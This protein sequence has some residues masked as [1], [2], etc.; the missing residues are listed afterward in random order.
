MVIPEARI[1][2]SENNNN[3]EQATDDGCV[4]KFGNERTKKKIIIIGVLCAVVILS[5][6]AALVVVIIVNNHAF[7]NTK[8]EYA[9]PFSE[10]MQFDGGDGCPAPPSKICIKTQKKSLK[11][12]ED[13]TVYIYYGTQGYLYDP[14]SLDYATGTLSMSYDR[15]DPMCNLETISENNLLLATDYVFDF[16]REPLAVTIPAEAFVEKEALK[17]PVKF[18]ENE[19]GIVFVYEARYLCHGAPEEYSWWDSTIIYYKIDNDNINLYTSYS[20]LKHN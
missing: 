6:S 14:D 1:M 2:T 19:G 12:G 20:G 4:P 3:T 17:D 9:D 11:K 16:E 8:T 15:Y 7:S 5:L 10:G 18:T 13:L